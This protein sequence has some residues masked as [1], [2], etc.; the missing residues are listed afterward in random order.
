MYVDISERSDNKKNTVWKN[1]L[2]VKSPHF[3]TGLE[4]DSLH[5]HG[6]S[7]PSATLVRVDLL[8]FSGLH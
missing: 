7:Q 6:S 3:S 1:D 2:V 8:S 5:P 4:T